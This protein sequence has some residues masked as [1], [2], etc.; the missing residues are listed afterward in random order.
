MNP[1]L[2][3]AIRAIR[4]GGN[5]LAKMYDKN[6]FLLKYT[7]FQ[8]DEY[9]KNI[10]YKTFEILY[11][12]IHKAY[13]QHNIIHLNEI[14]QKK[15]KNLTWIIYPLNGKLNFFKKI[16]NFC[17][18]ILIQDKKNNTDISVIY[19]PIKN[20]L[21]TTIKGK[22]TQLNGFRTRCKKYVPSKYNI[23]T[24]YND[25]KKYQYKNII[26]SLILKFIKENIHIRKSGSKILD[27]AYLSSGRMDG[28]IDLNNKYYDI[29]PGILQVKESGALI[30]DFSGGFNYINTSILLCG[31]ASF[32]KFIFKQI[33]YIKKN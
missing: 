5:F 23:I 8:E 16:S 11:T 25:Y 26:N 31:H 4:K 18:A 1:T 32:L 12:V 22:G 14:N 15:T 20:D 28:Y 10:Q 3:I 7:A 19:D 9:L 21:F 29:L 24:L 13:P 27:L 6:N 17:L 33:L 2:N 30:T